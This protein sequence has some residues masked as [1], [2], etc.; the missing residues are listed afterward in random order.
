MRPDSP[1]CHNCGIRLT[2]PFCAACGQKAV[3]LDIRLHDFFHEFVHEMA[4]V[5]GRIFQSILRL[6]TRPGYL[7]R[8]Y[9]QG[10]RVRW[11]SPIRL[12]LIFSLVYF[13][14][15]LSPAGNPVQLDTPAASERANAELQ[16]VGFNSVEDLRDTLN[17]LLRTWIPRAMFVLVPLFAGLTRL[18]YRRLDRNYLHHL[19]FALHVHAAWFA[20]GALAAAADRTTPRAVAD[21]LG[22]AA[23]LYGLTYLYFALRATFRGTARK[24]AATIALVLPVYGIAITAVILVIVL[25]VVRRLMELGR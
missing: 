15:S 14:A 2:G 25:P 8:E 21:W 3:R 20:A 12:Y 5:D 10:R 19:Y 16:K 23:L 17:Q 9:L 4:H 11:I 1:F 22:T 7:T 18:A 24:A 6:L 13:A